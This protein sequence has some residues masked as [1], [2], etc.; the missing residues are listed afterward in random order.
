MIRMGLVC[1]SGGAVF[2][3]AFAILKSC[4]CDLHTAVVTDRVCGVESIC[5]EIGVPVLRI[6]DPDRE[7]FSMKSAEWLYDVQGMEWSALF[8]SR[9]VGEP[10]YSRAPCVNFHPSL[11]PAFPGFGALK[12]TQNSGVKIFGATAHFAD[13]STDG[14]KILAQVATPVPSGATLEQL[15]RISFAQKLY[16]LL[17][18]CELAENGQMRLNNLCKAQPGDVLYTGYSN[19]S[20][21]RE[22]INKAFMDFVNKES[23]PWPW[24]SESA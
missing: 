4:G 11:L 16:L 9:L 12:N 1:S 17:V 13:H 6:N 15:G 14:G 19:P 3:A 24:R 8:F 2:G 10:L 20:L 5:A 7:T 23:I 22:D 21:R 18:M